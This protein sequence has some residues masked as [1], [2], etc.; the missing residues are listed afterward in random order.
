MPRR[1]GDGVSGGVSSDKVSVLALV[2]G[3]GGVMAVS[4]CRGKLGVAD[5]SR[6]PSCRPTARRATCGPWRRW[7]W[8]RRIRST[9]RSQCQK[10]VNTSIDVK[11]CRTQ[12]HLRAAHLWERPKGKRFSCAYLLKPNRWLAILSIREQFESVKA[13][14]RGESVRAPMCIRDKKELAARI[15]RRVSERGYYCYEIETRD[16]GD[17]F[18]IM[19]IAVATS[20]VL[21][22]SEE[23]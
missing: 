1:G 10:R 18:L 22:H 2:N 11:G 23:R 4:A 3:R 13:S 6:A 20:G 9:R 17:L 8:S 14:L 7:A 5:A 19:L 16:E 15:V 21:D 12:Y